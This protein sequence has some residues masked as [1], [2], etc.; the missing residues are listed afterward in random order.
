MTVRTRLCRLETPSGI[1]T[2]DLSPTSGLVHA[3]VHDREH[4]RRRLW[5]AQVALQPARGRDLLASLA[6]RESQVLVRYRHRRKKFEIS[7]SL[8]LEVAPQP[9]PA[10]ELAAR[11]PPAALERQVRNPLLEPIAAHAW[12]SQSVFNAGA[13]RIGGRV[14]L[15]YRAIGEDGRS[16]LGHA[17]S[18]NGLEFDHRS[19]EPVYADGKTLADYGQPDPDTCRQYQSGISTFGC[20]DPRITR[21]DDRLYMTYTAFDGRN[22]PAV[23]LT[24]I[25]VEDFAAGRWNWREPRL[26]SEPHQAHKNWVLFPERIDGR[27]ALLHGISPTMQIDF[28]DD[29]EFRDGHRVRS[30]Y[31]CSGNPGCWDNRIRGVGPPPIRTRAG[32]LLIYHAMDERDPGRYKLGAMLLDGDDPFRIIGRLPH[33]LL[34]PDARYENEGFKAGVVY[35]C[36]AVVI[37]DRLHV[38][39]G[40][41]DSV[42]C[43]AAVSLDR[44]LDQL[45]PLQTRA[46]VRR[47]KGQ[48]HALV[49]T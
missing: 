40:G 25:D 23:G 12:E 48:P 28:F 43:G 46:F 29:L 13:V 35:A 31:L 49:A 11:P 7:Y 19:T 15:L 3:A 38:Y 37:D 47:R 30:R 26:I 27:Y 24:S 33:P 10:P 17:A 34:E 18:E 41:A 5:Q 39:Y 20:E 4:P 22:P 2:L 16:V 45:Q 21:I 42:I 36:G 14:H 32:W 9:E 6:W 44:L 8:R 1:W